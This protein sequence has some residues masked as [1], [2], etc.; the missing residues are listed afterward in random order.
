MPRA[1][2][3]PLVRCGRAAG[4][5]S[6]LGLALS[7]VCSAADSEQGRES[8]AYGPLS[9]FA[10]VLQLVRQDY[11]DE[12]KVAFPSLIGGALR[13][14]LAGLDP[15]CQFLDVREYRAVQDDNRGRF[16]GVGLVLNQRDGLLSVMSVMDGSPGLKAGILAG[17]QLLKVDGQ[18]TEKLNSNDVA[19]LLRGDVGSVVK[20]VLYRPASRETREVELQREAIRLASVSDVKML[21]SIGDGN[22]VN[23]G[24]VRLGQFSA[25]TA[26]ELDKALGELEKKGMQALVLDLRNNPGG[27]LE[28]AIEVA[29]QFLPP[30]SIVV[31]TE[32][33][34]PSQNRV[35]RTSENASPHPPYPLAVLANAGSASAA[36]ILAGA[37]KDLRRAVV[38]GETTF[39]KGSVQSVIPLPDGTAIRLT[40]ARYYT[41]G[42]RAINEVGVQPTIRAVLTHEQERL[43]A[44]QRRESPLTEKERGE[45]ALF[46]DVQ[47]ERATDTL[48]ALASMALRPA[49]PAPQK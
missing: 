43:F 20:L 15:H 29:A 45:L 33:R 5:L 11:V 18:L 30:N 38:V 16:S 26:T 27:L 41:P 49:P 42:R 36:E 23:V 7:G 4:W 32:G 12:A 35:Y 24:Y 17:D 31:T 9:V 34:A 40:T 37:L 8:S 21:G 28:S 22:E 1:P 46:Q 10:K 6:A 2:L 48:R 3:F 13:G 39:G 19:S 14:M 47:L 25:T 44:L